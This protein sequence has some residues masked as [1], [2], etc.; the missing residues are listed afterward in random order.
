MVNM[1]VAH[2]LFDHE[3]LATSRPVTR[4]GS[5][6]AIRGGWKLGGV[7]ESTSKLNG[8]NLGHS[9]FIAYLSMVMWTSIKN[10]MDRKVQLCK[11]LFKILPKNHLTIYFFIFLRLN[12]FHYFVFKRPVGQQNFPRG[13]T[14]FLSP[15]A[16]YIYYFFFKKKL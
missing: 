9:H 2:G 10:K 7:V 15:N 13:S 11:S 8:D 1:R 14:W 4:G 16:S 5:R 6:L 12:I 3:W